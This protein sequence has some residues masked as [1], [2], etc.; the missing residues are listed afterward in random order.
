MYNDD[1]IYN[2]LV[3]IYYSKIDEF[4]NVKKYDKFK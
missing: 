3:I 1:L 2:I 4:C